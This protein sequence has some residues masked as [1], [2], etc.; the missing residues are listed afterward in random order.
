M[1]KSKLQGWENLI[2]DKCLQNELM[3]IKSINI[4]NLKASE[5]QGLDIYV[6][7]AFLKPGYHQFV[8][9]DPM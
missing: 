6:Y 1:L 2:K 5:D 9:Y 4:P 7:A 8:I 3:D